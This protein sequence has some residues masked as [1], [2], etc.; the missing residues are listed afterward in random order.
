MEQDT[1]V[2]LLCFEE[3]PEADENLSLKAIVL[4]EMSKP[5]VKVNAE[6]NSSTQLGGENQPQSENCISNP[7]QGSGKKSRMSGF[8]SALTPILKYLNTGNRRQPMEPL[9]C[10][11]NSLQSLSTNSMGVNCQQAMG[12][13]S[14]YPFS[15]K[16]SNVCWLDEECLP[17]ITLLDDAYE[18]RNNSALL[19]SMPATP[20]KPQSSMESVR[21]HNDGR[22][23]AERDAFSVSDKESQSSPLKT[24]MDSSAKANLQL[25]TAVENS[26]A[27]TPVTVLEK[28][29]SAMPCLRDDTFEC[30]ENGPVNLAQNETG[31][32]ALNVN[33]ISPPHVSNPLECAQKSNA[34]VRL[35][36][37]CKQNETIS[38]SVG[39]TVTPET[40]QRTVGGYLPETTL[41]DVTRDSDFLL[42]TSISMVKVAQEVSPMDVGEESR[43]FSD[44]GVQP[45]NIT[46]DMSVSSDVQAQQTNTSDIHRNNSLIIV[47]PESS[48]EPMNMSNSWDANAKEPTAKNDCESMVVE[49]QSSPKKGGSVR[50]TFTITP[51]SKLSTPFSSDKATCLRD[52]TVDLSESNA[53]NPKALGEIGGAD[54][55][56]DLKKAE[57]SLTRHVTAH[58]DLQNATFEWQANPKS[59]GS[60]GLGEVVAGTFCPERT[61]DSKPPCTQSDTIT[62]SEVS[63]SVN[64]SATA[65]KPSLSDTNSST[66]NQ[67]ESVNKEAPS[68]VLKQSGTRPSTDSQTKTT[69][70][71]VSILEA[72]PAPEVTPVAGNQPTSLTSDVASLDGEKRNTTF[73]LDDT[74]DMKSEPLVTSTPM[75]HFKV[76]PVT[77][78]HCTDVEAPGAQKSL[79]GK[80]PAAQLKSKI[81]SAQPRTC[82]PFYN[83][84][85]TRLRTRAE[86]LKG[87]AAS[88]PAQTTGISSCQNVPA[89]R[90]G[91]KLNTFLSR[92]SGFQRPAT[93]IRPPP[94]R[95]NAPTTG[96]EKLVV[97]T[98]HNPVVRP[99][100][101]RKPLTRSETL[102]TAK[103]KLDSV[104]PT[105]TTGASGQCVEGKGRALKQVKQSHRPQ[106]TKP[107]S[108]DSVVPTSTTGASGQ[109]GDGKGRALKQFKQSHR[110]Q[111]TKPQSHGCAE[112]GEQLQLQSEEITRLKRVCGELEEQLQL[113]SEEITR[114]KRAA[115][116]Q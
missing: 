65:D 37:L 87:P 6:G 103:R 116:I 53:T 74:L 73:N 48:V 63:S 82:E 57:T 7:S 3:N 19:E 8:R 55:S 89:T 99:T 80:E 14:Q 28:T 98:V 78:E 34:E 96:T 29:V 76:F 104:V 20:M 114:L 115:E 40:S 49:T 24:Q 60:N 9:K 84:P 92:P 50:N 61:F 83:Q 46:Y 16:T 47:N 75:P 94:A 67:V 43:C 88:E 64:C 21:H 71:T 52:N 17:E 91:S 38:I 86:A 51:S 106:L 26:S 36:K 68:E 11:R 90:K 2:S 110:P 97:P 58:S 1:T 100:Q 111:L 10:E 4:D 5:T 108:H 113:K 41:L 81:A 39:E 56:A 66:S 13:S 18:S 62:L 23:E 101:L 45:A 107:Q 32:V 93:G 112:C 12:M 72:N 15:T 59:T 70:T 85:M 33:N 27:Q 22:L 69:N 102:P 79:Y 42:E 31:Q 109:C 25:N 54:L 30:K 105:S 35:S 95:T 44:L 77:M